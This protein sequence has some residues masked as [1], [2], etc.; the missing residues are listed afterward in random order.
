M[1]KLIICFNLFLFCGAFRSRISRESTLNAFLKPDP[2]T[3]Q[4]GH[5]CP[6]GNRIPKDLIVRIDVQSATG[7][8]NLD[9]TNGCVVDKDSGRNLQLLSQFICAWIAHDFS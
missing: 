4:I 5:N 3:N 7:G 9:S 8:L 1:C 6:I 2:I